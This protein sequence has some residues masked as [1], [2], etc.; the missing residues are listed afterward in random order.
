M[1][2]FA[3]LIG[4]LLALAVGV[5]IFLP[6]FWEEAAPVPQR[7]SGDSDETRE[8]LMT[9]LANL[10][11]DF[12]SGKLDEA[13]YKSL[14]ASVEAQLLETGGQAS[15]PQEAMTEPKLSQIQDEETQHG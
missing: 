5:Y 6:Y 1:L 11:Y 7:A 10:E 8:K 2:M 15:A 14:R 4:L 12:R 13:S 9:D 3:P